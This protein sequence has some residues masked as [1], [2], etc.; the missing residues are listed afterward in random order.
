MTTHDGLRLLV[1]AV[2]MITVVLAAFTY[3]ARI[4]LFLGWLEMI[5]RRFEHLGLLI[6]EKKDEYLNRWLGWIRISAD[7][8]TSLRIVFVIVS[9][10]LVNDGRPVAAL[11][12]FCV[13]MVLDA[14]DGVIARANQRRT[15]HI[16]PH[17]MWFDPAADAICCVISM[18]VLFHR[19]TTSVVV[20][21]S[22]LLA[23]RFVYGAWVFG[24]WQLRRRRSTSIVPLTVFPESIAGKYKA[25]FIALSFALAI[26]VDPHH[27]ETQRLA[28]RMLWL[29]TVLEFYS[30]GQ[31]GIRWL[32]YRRVRSRKAEVIVLKKASNE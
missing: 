7:V 8:P 3:R 4:Q 31:Q 1:A 2:M 29:A 10:T 13:A 26:L 17:G 27:P 25:V 30:L 6:K 21:F 24:R 32:R 15:G 12:V 16:S 28:I 23:I 5:V 20:A 11:V 22:T 19:Y 9:M 14:I 18:A